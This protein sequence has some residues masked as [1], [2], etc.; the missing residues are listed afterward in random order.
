MGEF[1]GGHLASGAVQALGKCEIGWCSR[2]AGKSFA[3]ERVSCGG[4]V[5][6]VLVAATGDVDVGFG[7]VAVASTR[8]V[9]MSRVVVLRAAL[10]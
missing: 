3:V 10:R 4:D 7:R 8:L 5:E 9:E 6:V 1:P 2:D